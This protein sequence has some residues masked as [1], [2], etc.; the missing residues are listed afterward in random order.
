ME[1]KVQVIVNSSLS[2]EDW[3]SKEEQLQGK[4]THCLKRFEDRY[5][6][7][8]GGNYDYTC[9]GTAHNLF[10]NNLERLVPGW[11]EIETTELCPGHGIKLLFTPPKQKPLELVRLKMAKIVKEFPLL[12]NPIVSVKTEWF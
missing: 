4:L 5:D 8:A 7:T 10:E 12:G 6:N 2:C 9:P 11:Y 3:I 1:A